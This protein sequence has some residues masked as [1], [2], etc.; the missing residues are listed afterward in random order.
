MIFYR[1]QISEHTDFVRG[2]AWHPTNEKLYTCGWDSKILA[3]SIKSKEKEN[4]TYV[5]EVAFKDITDVNK[6]I[7]KIEHMDIGVGATNVET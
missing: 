2:L 3:S 7:S 1:D 4:G 5:S 6:K